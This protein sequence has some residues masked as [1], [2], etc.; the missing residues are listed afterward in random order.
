MLALEKAVQQTLRQER[1]SQE[2][3]PVREIYVLSVF[4]VTGM[5][6]F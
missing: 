1:S 3:C 2:P 5:A 4:F 6:F